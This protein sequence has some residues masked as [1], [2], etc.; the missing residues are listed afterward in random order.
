MLFASAT[1]L[2]AFL[3]AF[4]LAYYATPR[5]WRSFTLALASY[6]FYGWWRPDFLILMA[7]STLVD[8]S[9]GA[10]IHAARASGQR[11]K[12]WLALSLVCNLGLLAYFKYA[13]FGVDTLND[14]LVAMGSQ[15]LE[16]ARVILPVGISFYT[17]QT[18]SYTVD[19]YRGTTPPVGRFRDFMCYV[20]MFPQLVAGPI[21]RY[22]TVAEQLATRTHTV[23]KFFQGVLAFQ[24]GLAKKV[25]IADV[26]GTIADDVFSAHTVTTADAWLGSLAYTFQIYFD[27]SGYSDMAIGLG[28]MIGFRLPVNFDQPYRSRSITEFWQRWHISLST[29]LRDYLYLPLGGNRRG[30]L[31]TYVNLATVMLLGGLWHGAAWSF[32]AWGAYQGFWLVLERAG[33]KRSLYARAPRVAQLALT[34]VV[35]IVGWV[36]F[37]AEDLPAAGRV[38]TSMV[39]A[40]P[41]SVSPLAFLLRPIHLVAFGVAALILWG[42]PTTQRL[43]RAPPLWWTVSLQLAFPLALAHM[44]HEQN[45]P[46]LY[47]QF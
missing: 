3:P 46:F 36:L 34:F 15:P 30:A 33:G 17:F 27:F 31:R 37:R 38:L 22:H 6:V 39:G 20:A 45:V 29:F 18:L 47:F 21:V 13:N 12:R 42:L 26:L 32:F 40:V 41:E 35:V 7:V 14:L 10:R 8:F 24:A 2:Y 4:L 5:T 43:L 19:V 23:G 1:F 9:A 44:H 16:W 11:G 28:L 25:L